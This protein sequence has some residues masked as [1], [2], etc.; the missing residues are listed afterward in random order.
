M[1][2]KD[3]RPAASTAVSVRTEVKEIETRIIGASVGSHIGPGVV[4]I[5]FQKK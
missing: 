2:Q 4:A 3:F 5:I 1:L